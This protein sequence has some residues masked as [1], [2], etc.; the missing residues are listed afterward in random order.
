[1]SGAVTVAREAW[2]AALPDWVLRLAEACEE[3]SQNKVARRL[4]RSPALVSQVLRNKYAAELDLV[5]ELVTGKL[6]AA[7]RDCPALGELPLDQCQAWRRRARVFNGANAQ[8]V[9]MYR[10]CHRCPVFLVEARK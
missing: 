1:M 7:T 6:L 5:E 10:A 8:G 3:T 2:G 9:K 4:E